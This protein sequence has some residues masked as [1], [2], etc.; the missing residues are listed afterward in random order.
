M[1]F[2]HESPAEFLHFL[3]YW[4]H[5][6]THEPYFFSLK[7]QRDYTTFTC[8]E[9]HI[10]IP[11]VYSRESLSSRLTRLIVSTSFTEFPRDYVFL[12][13]PFPPSQP[14]PT[15]RIECR[16]NKYVS[17]MPH[18]LRVSLP[19]GKARKFSERTRD[20][21]ATKF[22]N[23]QRV[24][25]RRAVNVSRSDRFVYLTRARDNRR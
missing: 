17:E 3:G 24:H 15:R 18:C 10:F 6:W 23:V 2:C 11:F 4:L 14:S 25:M 22:R 16:R 8:R 19:P 1:L 21:A 20:A 5:C 13:P 7:A 9:F 12:P